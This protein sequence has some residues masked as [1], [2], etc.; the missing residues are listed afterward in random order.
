MIKL[1]VAFH[2]FAN[3]PKKRE[4]ICFGDKSPNLGNEGKLSKL[5]C[6]YSEPDKVDRISV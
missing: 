1:I 6:L 4:R 3:A 2:N 5:Q